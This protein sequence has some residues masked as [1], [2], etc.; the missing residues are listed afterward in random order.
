MPKTGIVCTIGPASTHETILRSMVRSGMHIARLNFSHSARK[1]L[2]A[3]IDLIRRINSKC[4]KC[5]KILGDLEGPRIRM[6]SI[7]GSGPIHLKKNQVLWLT[8]KD[9][10]GDGDTASFDYPGSLDVIKNGHHIF[11]DDGTI[12]L[13]VTGRRKDA[14]KTEVVVGGNLKEHK[15][16]NIPDAKLVFR[17]LSRDDKENIRFSVKHKFEYIAQ[18]F[19]RTK[20]D[21]L[22]VK[23]LLPSNRNGP[24][25]IAKIESR[26]GILNI[27]DIIKASDGIMVARGDMG[28]AIPIYKVPVVQKLII[29][30]CNLAGK[31]VITATQMLE[32]MTENLIPTRAEV[33]DVANA[34]IDG[35]DYVMLSGESAVG[36]H[37]A[38]TVRMMEEIIKFTES[39]L[40]GEAKI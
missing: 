8:N 11:I 37:P 5:V 25:V 15:G 13:K 4:N 2:L 6:G 22:K 10:E 29:K 31:P 7:A 38:E 40:A 32:S 9:V 34:I 30:K 21:I 17:G 26:E 19:V 1:D 20:E 12:A 27:D 33:T 23:A 18:S 35:T 39:Y 24:K 28:I 16:V 3:R 36:K 14:L